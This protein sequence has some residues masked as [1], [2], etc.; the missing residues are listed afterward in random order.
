[1]AVVIQ[2]FGKIMTAWKCDN[3]IKA[4]WHELF[5]QNYSYHHKYVDKMTEEEILNRIFP[6][7]FYTI[8]IQILMY[9]LYRQSLTYIVNVTGPKVGRDLISILNSGKWNFLHNMGQLI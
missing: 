6:E 7:R 5:F 9:L 3:E 2:V 1:M 8:R 4:W